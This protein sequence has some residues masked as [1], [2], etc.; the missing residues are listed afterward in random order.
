MFSTRTQRAVTLVKS[1]AYEA[2]AENVTFM[3][4]SIAYHAFI[5]LFPLLLLLLAV[6]SAVGN[7][8]LKQAFMQLAQTMLTPGASEVL[9]DELRRASAS[10]GISIVSV[11][12]LFW[13]TMRI[14][15]GLD[16]A[17]SD[18][19]A[20]QARNTLFDQFVDGLVVLATVTAII[21]VTIV[22]EWKTSMLPAGGFDWTLRRLVLVGGLALMFLPMYYVFP[23]VD[24][25]SIPEIL[26]GVL[27]ATVGVTVLESLFHIYIT[28]SSKSPN[29][30]IVAAF[31]LL[32]TWL[33]LS[34]VV[35]LLGA[36]VNAVTANRSENVNVRPLTTGV[37]FKE[38]VPESDAE[39]LLATLDKLDDSTLNVER[40][41]L[42]VDGDDV[43][44][45]SPDIFHV[46]TG[47][48]GVLH[49][50]SLV[51]VEFYWSPQ[52]RRGEWQDD[53]RDVLKNI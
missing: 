18:I 32:L 48:S 10:P 1:I 47:E 45:P 6:I 38:Q 16:T 33:Y 19:Y 34:G 52:G 2:R 41:V 11:G 36:V 26:P 42:D 49:G 43:V 40:I 3:A 37:P 35:V 15:R 51:G 8:S 5:S 27:I 13:G 53:L 14:F 29:Q 4:A 31:L 50:S 7:L 22:V 44:I 30:S 9:V 17:F 20:S 12:F 28:F 46:D 24:D 21:V 39:E 25:L 23:D